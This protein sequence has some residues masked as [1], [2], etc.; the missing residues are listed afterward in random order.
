MIKLLSIISIF[1]IAFIIDF[2]V[3]S[4]LKEL[5]KKKC[6]CANKKE[7][8]YLRK[9]LTFSISTKLFTYFMILLFIMIKKNVFIK[10]LKTNGFLLFLA[11]FSSFITMIYPILHFI[12]YFALYH[13][14]SDVKKCNC[15]NKKKN[16]ILMIYLITAFIFFM[17]QFF[18]NT[19]D[20]FSK[21]KHMKSD[22]ISTKK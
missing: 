22:F 10:L 19:L 12:Y 17:I 9:Y 6:K 2:Y 1:I 15:G 18:G 21:F 14:I 16:T 8:L 3:Y 11:L 5:S 20:N 7:N 4:Y 13:Y